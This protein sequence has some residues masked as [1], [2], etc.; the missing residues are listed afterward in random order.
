M[1]TRVLVHLILQQPWM[2]SAGPSAS[3]CVFLSAFA[4]VQL[5]SRRS[6]FHS[7]VREQCSFDVKQLILMEADLHAE[8]KHT[9]EEY[10]WTERLLSHSFP[11][12]LLLRSL[13]AL[14]HAMVT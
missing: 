3:S 6:F 10:F 9:E 5:L 14:S 7:K 8:S 11:F 2:I 13:A 4:T 1:H 12:C